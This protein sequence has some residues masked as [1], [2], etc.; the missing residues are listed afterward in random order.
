MANIKVDQ[1]QPLLAF[2]AGDLVQNKVE[3]GNYVLLVTKMYTPNFRAVCFAK[4]G[5]DWLIEEEAVYRICDFE[6]FSGTMTLTQ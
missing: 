5:K 6:L 1:C 2:Q 4:R 3:K